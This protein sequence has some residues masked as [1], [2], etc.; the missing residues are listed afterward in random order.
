MKAIIAGISSALLVGTVAWAQTGRENPTAD[1][2]LINGQIHTMDAESTV[3]EAIGIEDGEIIYVGDAEGLGNVIGMG[4][5][6]FN[7]EGNMI[8][9]GFVDGHSHPVAGGLIMLGVDLQTDDKEELFAR[10][11]KEVETNDAE[12]ILGYGVRFNPWTDGNPTAAMLDEIESERP[13]YFWT[14]DAHGAWVN[15]K[16]LEV[17]GIDKDTP[18]TAP[19]FSFFE[20][21]EDG[22]PTGWIVEIPAQMQVLSA[23][24]DP[25]PEFM[26]P[27]VADWME[28]F[29]AA[30]ITAAH[31]HGIQGMGQDEGFEM[32]LEF[33]EAGKLPL[34]VV[35]SYYWNDG[36]FDP[37]PAL[38]EIREKYDTELVQ[39]R[40]LKVNMDGGD[41]KWNALYVDPYTDRPD[42][43]PEPI[44][45]YQVVEDTVIRADAAGI[46]VTCHCWGDQ[47]VR[48]LLDAIEAAIATNPPRERRH[49]ITHGQS[50]HPDDR[51]RFAELGVIYDTT[52]AW[53]TYDPLAQTIATDR[54]GPERVQATFPAAQVIQAGGTFSLGS[55]W[56]ASGYVSEYRPL[57]NIEYAVT[58]TL[59]GRKDVPPLGGEDA[60]L[61]VDQALRAQTINAAYGM[62]LSD[63][64]GSLEVGKKADIVVLEKNLYDIDPN[65]ISEVEVLFTIMNGTLTYDH[66]EE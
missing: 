29:A 43:V 44:I 16:A 28:R 62:G 15:S 13:V 53:M 35:G 54:L 41:D 17:A 26:A 23:L 12:V 48:Y 51:A 8:L 58:R 42:I 6:V 21:D 66:R 19:G 52:G 39:A 34:R 22:N 1:W 14:I 30:G 45:P 38:M 11:R 37:L 61:T 47:A 57:A 27:G 18:D 50:V 33:E 31:D 10:I 65:D 5:E 46:N 59:D 3:A 60:K 24:I 56:P 25:T 2:A 36:S 4:T 49:K 20:R 64:I 9:P 32:L 63:Q 7:L 40:Y 55:D